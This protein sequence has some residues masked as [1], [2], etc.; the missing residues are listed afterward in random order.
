MNESSN[1]FS[2]L[3]FIISILSLVFCILFSLYTRWYINRRTSASGL[4]E[5]YRSEVYRLNAE[6]DAVTDRDAQL[7]EERIKKLKEILEDA[8]KRLKG[9][10]LDIER[11]R[12]GE[13]L[14]TSLGRG[15]RAALKTPA[16][17]SPVP[18]HAPAPELSKQMPKLTPVRQ[19]IPPAAPAPVSPPVSA[20]SAQK[21]PSNRQIRVQIE[22]LVK[23]GLAPAEIASRLGVS[24][25]EVD[26]AMN[27]MIGRK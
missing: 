1:V 23:E 24:I 2:N 18:T 11:N 21:P 25:A 15:I 8:D 5:E 27:L 20:P 22:E 16:E 19:E 17:T 6:I 3:S 9:Y 14:Y 7:V 12:A 26:L 10:D 4:L 13:A